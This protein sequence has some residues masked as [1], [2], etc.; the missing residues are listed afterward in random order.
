M[1]ETNGEQSTQT[2]ISID[3]FGDYLARLE[4]DGGYKLAEEYERLTNA[5]GKGCFARTAAEAPE[6]SHK[7][8]YSNVLP[9]KRFPRNS[10]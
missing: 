7:N 4:A 1:V 2:S 5:S 10:I 8:R 6:N 3:E 9:C